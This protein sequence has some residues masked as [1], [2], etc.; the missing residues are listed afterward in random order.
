MPTI[1]FAE[2]SVSRKV[3]RFLLVMQGTGVILVP[4]LRLF[5]LVLPALTISFLTLILSLACL[6]W[7]YARYL[8]LPIIRYR[9]N[10]Q[11]FITRF[12]RRARDEVKVIR[13]TAEERDHLLYAEKE[14]IAIALMTAQTNH[15]DQ[16]LASALVREAAIP[17]VGPELK[18][19]LAKYGIRNAAQLTEG[20]YAL[21]GFGEAECRSLIGWRRSLVKSLEITKPHELAE[22]QLEPIRQKYQ[23]L[24]ERNGALEGRARSSKELLER[25]LVFLKPLFQ[26]LAPLTFAYYLSKSLASPA[27]TAR[28]LACGLTLAQA[29]SLVIAALPFGA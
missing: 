20:I 7:L 22:R 13:R 4:C 29:I 12:E 6:A 10:L 19:R 25:E 16:G 17:G 28:L 21:P 1:T 11:R 14:E 5:H 3:T 18:D 9:G 2:E 24:Q 8:K 26:E 15:M 23:I 27:W